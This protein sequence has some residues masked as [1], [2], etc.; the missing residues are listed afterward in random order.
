LKK[1]G[2]KV[3]VIWQCELKNKQQ[4]QNTLELL[5]EQIK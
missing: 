5:E 1:N 2:W 4:I 3:I